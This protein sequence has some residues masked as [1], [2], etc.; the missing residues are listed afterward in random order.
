MDSASPSMDM[1]MDAT[2]AMAMPSSTGDPMS[3]PSSNMTMSMESMIMVFFTSTNTPLWSSAFTP[4]TAGQYA[5]ACI[6]LIA[7]AVV[8][9]MLLALRFNLFKVVAVVK[10]R[11]SGGLLQPDITEIKA[12]PRPWRASEAILSG[13]LDTVIAGVSYLLMVAVMTMNVGYFLS[14][15]GGVFLG[16][17]LCN[18]LT[19]SPGGH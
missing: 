3:M 10:K 12:T 7:F 2:S 16:S 15:L 11:R 6:F 4:N 9:R 8:F 1:S 14:V 5:G 18:H 19:G 17:V 13:A